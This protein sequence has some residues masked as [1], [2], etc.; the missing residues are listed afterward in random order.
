MKQLQERIQELE[1]S[2]SELL[3]RLNEKLE[4]LKNQDKDKPML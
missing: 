3:D 2:Q 4:N 1:K